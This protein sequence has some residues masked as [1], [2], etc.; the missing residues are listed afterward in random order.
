MARHNSEPE[1]LKIYVNMICPF[2]DENAAGVAEEKETS[3]GVS[4]VAFNC[5]HCETAIPVKH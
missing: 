5:P 4:F 1:H 3:T 2:C